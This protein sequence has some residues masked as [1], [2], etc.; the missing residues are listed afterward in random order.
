VTCTFELNQILNNAR[1][2]HSGHCQEIIQYS[3]ALAT[4]A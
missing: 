1:H 2:R 4:R 3:I